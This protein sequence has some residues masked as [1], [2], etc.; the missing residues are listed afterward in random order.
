MTR[1][2]LLLATAIATCALAAPAF[3]AGPAGSLTQ[4]AGNAGCIT[5]NGKS[6]AVDAQ[7]AD[8]RGLAGAEPVV[9]S[10]D[11]K[12]A[13]SYGWTNGSVAIFSRDPATGALSQ[14][15]DPSACVARVSLGGDCTAGRM[16]SAGS[17]SAHSIAITPDG[18]FLFVA[19]STGSLVSV[20]SRD[21]TTGTL[22][23]VPGASGCISSGGGDANGNAT[24]SAFPQMDTT[25]SLALSPDG[26][27]LYV[28]GFSS[29]AGLTIFSV[30]ATGALTPLANPNGCVSQSASASCNQERYGDKLYDIALSPDGHTLYAVHDGVGSAAVLAFTRDAGT[31][32]VQQPDTPGYCVFDG[33]AGTASPCTVGHG[34]AQP[35]SVEVS[36]DGKL[37]VVGTYSDTTD[38][39]VVLHRDTG[40]GELSQSAGEA[41]CLNVA[42]ADG[43][44]LSRQTADAYRALFTP[45]GKTL[46]VAGYATGDA[47]KSGIA[48]FDVNADGTLTQRAGA[49]GCYSASGTD[50]T[51]AAGGC[52]TARGVLGPVGLA[53]SADGKT[54]YEGAYDDSGIA[55]FRVESAPACT[56]ASANTPFGTAV[57]VPVACMDANGDTLSLAGVDGPA[58]GTATFSGLSATYTPAAG[59]S[60][61]DT[62]RVKGTDGAGGDS[63]PATVT[64]HVG[65]A[66]VVAKKPPK[67]VS[68]KAK[69]KRDR[70]LPYVFTFSGQLELPAGVTAAQGCSG[71]VAVTVKRAKKTV[72]KKSVKVLASCKWKA[73]AA[74]KNR[75][76][77]GKKRSGTLTARARFGGNAVLT[78]QSAKAVKVR[79]G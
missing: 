8:G 50:S 37:V 25:Q 24:C 31:G 14:A 27:F 42:Q 57:V 26:N 47:N 74:F 79:Y 76:K 44:G 39:I 5:D 58:H 3:A 61:D 2:P 51:G 48:V 69:P 66:P 67:K 72:F 16:P 55:T 54:L 35:Q 78:A 4:L 28:G 75:K 33:G 15:N 11:G 29:T 53:L 18:A 70:T 1:L 56:D 36:P 60:G 41:G 64:V 19:G 73:V 34:L 17:D 45:D 77:L 12:F 59:F 43:C 20:F 10:P 21:A 9:L 30:G 65:A 6:N 49:L 38:G 22:S 68:L 62:F 63:A 71:K 7:C 23:E 52:T 46:Y 13:Y 40:T 32:T